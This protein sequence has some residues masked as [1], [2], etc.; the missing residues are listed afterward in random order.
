MAY[1]HAGCEVNSFCLPSHTA[2]IQC[3]PVFACVT[4]CALVSGTH[5]TVEGAC[6]SIVGQA[7]VVTLLPLIGKSNAR[8][9]TSTIYLQQHPAMY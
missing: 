6:A 7:L 3:V 1:T 2:A 4:H 8:N 9:S 5:K